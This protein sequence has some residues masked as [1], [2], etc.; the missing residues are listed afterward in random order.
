MG[1]MCQM[2]LAKAL[3]TVAK[4]QFL[5]K[6]SILMKFTQTLNLNFPA[7]NGIIENLIFEQ[8]LGFCH[9]VLHA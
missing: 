2:A 3:H 5:S 7:K 9:S 8:K 4:F 1:K 6:N